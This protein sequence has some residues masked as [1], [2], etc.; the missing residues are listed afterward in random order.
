MPEERLQKILSHAGITSRRKAEEMIVDG[1]VSVNGAVI[2]ELGSKADLSRD[3]IKVDGKLLRPPRRLLYI[4]L[5][6]PVKFDALAAM[7]R[8]WSPP[9][10]EVFS[11]S[12][13]LLSLSEG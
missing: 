4:A 2:T 13:P 7:L 5:N 9:P 8:K 3:H 10:A 11:S 6:K 12:Y 1:R